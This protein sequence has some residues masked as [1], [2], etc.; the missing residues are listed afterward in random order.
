MT[1]GAYREFVTVGGYFHR[2]YWTAA[3]W[4]WRK[5]VGRTQPALWDEKKWTADIRLPVVGVSWYEALAY[6]RWLGE[7]TGERYRLPA[8]A[9]S[10]KAARGRDGR[11]FPWGDDFDPRRCNTRETGLNQTEPVGRRCPGGE[12]LWL[13]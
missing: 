10:E 7:E 4:S 1:V 9:E 12:P 3:G 2:N 6:C 11:I 13:C 5:R 8:E